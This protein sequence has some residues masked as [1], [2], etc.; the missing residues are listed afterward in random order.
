MTQ[1]V[2]LNISIS[3]V[4][5]RLWLL[6]LRAF[7][8]V[9]LLIGLFILAATIIVLGSQTNR[10][11]F[12]RAPVAIL[13]E[14]YYQ[15]HGSWQGVETLFDQQTGLDTAY[16]RNEWRQ[17]VLL[18]TSGRML[19]DQGEVDEMQETIQSQANKIE[20]ME[21]IIEILMND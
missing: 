16:L 15:A 9:A 3:N 21:K 13:L 5:R 18:D 7:G 6:L 8:V 10:N 1:A 19:I 4:R 2:D 12:Y 11:P 20:K 17:A 14:T